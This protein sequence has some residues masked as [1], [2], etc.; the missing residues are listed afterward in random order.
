MKKVLVVSTET[1]TYNTLLEMPD[2]FTEFDLDDEIQYM[3][4]N[5]DFDFTDG[6]STYFIKVNDWKIVE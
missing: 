6:E 3:L 4:E 2:D 1:I 5:D